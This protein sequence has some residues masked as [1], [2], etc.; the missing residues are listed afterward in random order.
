M[1]G[2]LAIVHKEEFNITKHEA[3]KY[4]T[5]ELAE[6]KIKPCT[7]LPATSLTII[8]RPPDSD[9]LSFLHELSDCLERSIVEKGKVILLGNF[10]IHI[11]RADNVDAINFL[12]FLDS[13]GQINRVDF[14]TH[15]LANTLDC[16]SHLRMTLQYLAHPKVISSLII[17]W[18][19]LISTYPRKN[20]KRK[21]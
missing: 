8:Y 13:F 18:S 2:G 9:V 4:Q 15:G 17:M 20:S 3:P 7:S 11:N 21:P 19:F 12:D 14:P 10:N 16:S 1:G 5:V 6:F